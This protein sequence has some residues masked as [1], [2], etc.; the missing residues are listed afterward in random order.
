MWLEFVSEWEDVWICN[1]KLR[2]ASAWRESILHAE[3]GKTGRMWR[4]EIDQKLC[5]LKRETWMG[6]LDC[7]DKEIGWKNMRFSL[8]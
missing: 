6:G 8:K 3:S 2:S 4:D 5:K 1:I 7:A